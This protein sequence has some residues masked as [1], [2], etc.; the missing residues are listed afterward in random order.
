MKMKLSELVEPAPPVETLP[1]LLPE[2]QESVPVT[3]PSV[4]PVP[5]VPSEPPGILPN[6]P[7]SNGT[8]TA[9]PTSVTPSPSATVHS[10]QAAR[11]RAQLTPTERAELA[12]KQLEHGVV[13]DHPILA[14]IAEAILYRRRYEDI[15]AN[16]DRTAQR[17]E[18]VGRGLRIVLHPYTSVG[19]LLIGVAIVALLAWN[20]GADV[21]LLRVHQPPTLVPAL[22]A[23]GLVIGMTVGWFSHRAPAPAKSARSRTW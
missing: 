1:A 16:F 23:L 5:P 19:V 12:E 9:P 10:S 14:F 22:L 7:D 8:V 3:E 17:I 6:I 11:L 13:D 18:R 20:A 2:A 4:P 15:L 21:A